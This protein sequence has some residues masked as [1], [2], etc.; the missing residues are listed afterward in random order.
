MPTTTVIFED[1]VLVDYSFE[2]AA[3]DPSIVRHNIESV[4]Q[5]KD[6]GSSTC[7]IH[8]LPCSSC[9]GCAAGDNLQVPQ[10]VHDASKVT[11]LEHK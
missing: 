11:S 5:T 9:G 3:V 2:E 8:G 7:T 1:Q 6:Q 10:A 4:D